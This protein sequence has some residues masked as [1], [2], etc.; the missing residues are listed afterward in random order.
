MPS[1]L[2]TGDIVPLSGKAQGNPRTNAADNKGCRMGAQL[3]Y[4]TTHIPA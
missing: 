4:A 1:S 3:T 2:S